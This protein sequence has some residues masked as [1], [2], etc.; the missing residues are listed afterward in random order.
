[1]NG[2]C[3]PF[4]FISHV[5]AGEVDL[6]TGWSGRCEKVLNWDGYRGMWK[7][8]NIVGM[9]RPFKV[10]SFGILLRST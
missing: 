4:I 8:T 6:Q 5:T 10:I 9:C 2:D 3:V 7:G 1:V